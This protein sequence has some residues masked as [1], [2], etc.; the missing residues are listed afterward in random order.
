MHISN[1]QL[2]ISFDIP[3]TDFS[4]KTPNSLSDIFQFS[5]STCQSSNQ[6]AEYSHMSWSVPKVV[7]TL[8]VKSLDTMRNSCKLQEDLSD[9]E[10][11]FPK[12]SVLHP[13][14]NRF[15]KR[16]FLM[17][18]QKIDYLMKT[19]VIFDKEARS[20]RDSPSSIYE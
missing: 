2:P 11:N 5:L 3:K 9:F 13:L 4:L 12:K 7:L 17:R 15:Y 18:H 20:L 14:S 6:F 8:S 19:K 10:E 16:S 1:F